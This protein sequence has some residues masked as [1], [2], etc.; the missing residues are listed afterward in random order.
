MPAAY[1]CSTYRLIKQTGACC[2]FVLLHPSGERTRWGEDHRISGLI[3]LRLS[4][5]Q[6]TLPQ[7]R[8]ADRFA[9]CLRGSK[10]CT[11]GELLNFRTHLPGS[12]IHLGMARFAFPRRTTQTPWRQLL[13]VPVKLNSFS[14]QRILLHLPNKSVL[15]EVSASP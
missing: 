1:M 12:F 5:T 13:K 6:S 7:R 11:T 2:S 8:G 3:L 9:F 14:S 10:C 15:L 4:N